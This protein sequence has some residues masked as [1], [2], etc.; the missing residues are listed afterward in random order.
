MSPSLPTALA[1]F[2]CVFGAALLGLAIRARLPEA[3]LGSDTKDVVKLAMG[4]VATMSALVLGLL[5]ASAQNTFKTWDGEVKQSAADVILLDRTLAHLGPETTAIRAQLR[6]VVATRLAQ[7]WPEHGAAAARVDE[8]AQTASVE[9]IEQAIRDLPPPDAAQRDLQ[10][11]ALSLCAQLQ[12]TR[13]LL[14][15]QS[16][17]GIPTPFLVVLVF[18]LSALAISFGLFAPRNLTVIAALLLCSVSVSASVFL[19][20]EMSTPLAGL[21]KISSAPFDYALAH[22]GQ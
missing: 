14:F 22:L 12:G 21:L 17:S 3:H 8:S 1:V 9:G 6:A 2:T 4:L 16:D 20:L 18:W 13:W 15:A 19:I 11:R 5:T 7:T 10:T